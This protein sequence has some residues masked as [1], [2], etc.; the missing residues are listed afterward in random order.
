M[1][2]EIVNLIYV[3]SVWERVGQK[4]QRAIDLCGDDYSTADLWQMCRSG[5]AF[6]IIARE[7][8]DIAMAS[9]VRFEKWASGQVLRVVGIAGDRMSEWAEDWQAFMENMAREGGANRIVS[10][11]RDGWHRVFRKARKLRVVYE[12]RV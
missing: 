8:E 10:E 9:V 11:G 7:G 2:I 4:F 12:M 1:N 5:S 3:D 6:L